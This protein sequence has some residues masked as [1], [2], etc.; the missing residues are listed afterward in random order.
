MLAESLLSIESDAIKPSME[1]GAFEALWANGVSSFKQLRDKLALSNASLPSDLVSQST[2]KQFYDRTMSRL[3]SAGVDHFGV[4]IDGTLDYPKRL[5]DA[6]YPLVLF[7]Y[8]G[9]WDLVYTPG[10]SV[11]GT[12]KPSA[13]G[14]RRAKRLVKALVNA[15]YTIYSGLATGIDTAAHQAAIEYGGF[16]VAVTG[17]P[18]WLNYPKENAALQ[19]EITKNHLLISQVPVLSYKEKD[20]N[21][22][23]LFF[24]ER[25]ITMAAL[26]IA[27]I[28]V[29]AGETSGTLKQAKAALKQGRKVF[30]LNS[31]FENPHLTWP[32]K[33]EDKGAI[34]VYDIDDVL[35]GLRS[36]INQI[37]ED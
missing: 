21:F 1:I 8:Q 2:A 37:T 10:I 20:I 31:N 25:N 36:E 15:K 9:R 14:I 34:R 23:R 5:H 7:Y 18:L 26:S 30:I 6:D 33:L 11:V 28:I 4:R 3:H 35:Q 27:T 17:A 12:R 19:K 16:T 24:P 22:T 32:K 29:E 13:E